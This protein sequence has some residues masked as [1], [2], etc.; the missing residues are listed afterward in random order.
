MDTYKQNEN[1]LDLELITKYKISDALIEKYNEYKKIL[2]S[3]DPSSPLYDVYKE[4]LSSYDLSSLLYAEYH[5]TGLYP[6]EIEFDEKDYNKI[7]GCRVCGIPYQIMCQSSYQK[8]SPFAKY[9]LKQ[10]KNV[11]KYIRCRIEDSM[12]DIF[13]N[14]YKNYEFVPIKFETDCLKARYFKRAMRSD[15]RQKSAYI[16]FLDF[17]AAT[18]LFDAELN[19]FEETSIIGEKDILYR[20]PE[21]NGSGIEEL[22]ATY[23]EQQY[24]ITWDEEDDTWSNFDEIFEHSEFIDQDYEYYEDILKTYP[25]QYSI[26]RWNVNGDKSP[27]FMS[28]IEM[29]PIMATVIDMSIYSLSLSSME[30]S[31]EYIEKILDTPVEKVM[32]LEE[33]VERGAIL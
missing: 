15:G 5:K 1:M 28:K 23:V 17:I 16:N 3:C 29:T 31:I 10:L 26:Y 25:N 14:T 2:S 22:V 32:S 27:L 20:S 19:N 18:G 9:T 7:I 12:D 11:H 6:L 8:D 4:I 33:F 24:G 21:S 30:R 13:L